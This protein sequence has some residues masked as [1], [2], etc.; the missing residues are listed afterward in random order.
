MNAFPRKI[1]L[2]TDGSA[3]AERATEAASDLTKRAEAE[4]PPRTAP[5]SSPP[6]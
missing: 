3:D 4:S 5:S 6:K 2:A 1:L